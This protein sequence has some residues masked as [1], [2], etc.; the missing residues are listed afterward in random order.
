MSTVLETKAFL[1]GKLKKHYMKPS[2]LE[3]QLT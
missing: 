2:F 3:L 1:L